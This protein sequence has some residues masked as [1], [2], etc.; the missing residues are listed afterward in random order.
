METIIVKA[1]KTFST[2]KGDGLEVMMNGNRKATVAAW[3]KQEQTYIIN[4][5]G[6]GGSFTGD[7]IVKGEYT[8]IE[9]IDFASAV[10]NPNYSDPSPLPGIPVVNRSDIMTQPIHEKVPAQ[11]QTRMHDARSESILSQ[12]YLKGAIEMSKGHA[13]F[14]SLQDEVQYMSE[15]IVELH[16]LYKVGLALFE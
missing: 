11:P 10:K 4:D 12:V 2:A 13:P 16:G 6:I 5:V 8:N 14:A 15:C 3:H 7:V 1:L 9:N